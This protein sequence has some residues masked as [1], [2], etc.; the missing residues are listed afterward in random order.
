MKCKKQYSKLSCTLHPASPNDNIIQ[1]AFHIH[2]FHIC[3]SNQQTENTQEKNFR[4]FQ[5][6]K[7]ELAEH[8]QLFM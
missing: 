6:A 1:L 2:R 4:K 8:W 3:G 5:K 7:L